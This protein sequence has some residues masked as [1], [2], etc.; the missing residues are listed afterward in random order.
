MRITVIYNSKIY[1]IVKLTP[2]LTTN[3]NKC[4]NVVTDGEELKNN[5]FFSVGQGILAFIF[6]QSRAGRWR[7]GCQEP[8]AQNLRTIIM[9]I[10]ETVSQSKVCHE[11]KRTL[12]RAYFIEAKK[13]WLRL[14]FC[15]I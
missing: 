3:K 15:G 6:I 9:D 4:W 1:F 14:N 10:L 8:Q 12:A 11:I 2:L 13:I 5:R 7:G